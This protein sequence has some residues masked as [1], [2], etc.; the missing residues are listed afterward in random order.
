MTNS[1]GIGISVR[2]SL[3]LLEV[4]VPCYPPAP[5]SFNPQVVCTPRAATAGAGRGTA[6][7]NAGGGSLDR[8]PLPT[9][10]LVARR[11]PM[12]V[13]PVRYRWRL[14]RVAVDRSWHQTTSTG[15]RCIRPGRCA[16]GRRLSGGV[17]GELLHRQKQLRELRGRWIRLRLGRLC[18]ER[19]QGRVPSGDLIERSPARMRR[20]SGSRCHH[21]EMH[22]SL[23]CAIAGSRVTPVP[24]YGIRTLLQESGAH[25]AAPS[26]CHPARRRSAIRAMPHDT[27][28]HAG[29]GHSRSLAPAGTSS[30]PYTLLE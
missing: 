12:P 29:T 28:H 30:V 19:L 27:A 9:P 10:T 23:C 13:R 21:R 24:V 26:P 17:Y 4:S 3:R 8:E 20:G 22:N 18:R 15:G 6:E 5:M 1:K 11:G 16:A 2:F 25:A 14:T 7:V